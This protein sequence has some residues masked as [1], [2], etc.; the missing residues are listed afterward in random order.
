ME[1]SNISRAFHHLKTVLK[2]KYW[3]FRYAWMAGIPFRGIIHD[4][5]KFSPTEFCKSVKWYN[6]KQ[7]PV[8]CE[9]EVMGFSEIWL[10]HRGH[11]SHHFEYWVYWVDK[12]KDKDLGDGGVIVP[13]MPFKD[14]LEMVCDWLGAGRAYLGTDF[15][16]TKQI[17]YFDRATNSPFIH[18]QTKLFVWLMYQGLANASDKKAM[19]KVFKQ[20]KDIYGRAFDTVI[21]EKDVMCPVKYRG[22]VYVKK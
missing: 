1:F 16:M 11:N 20:A 2:H 3:V 8:A 9:R 14:A 7:S 13:I 10:H 15:S 17:E 19:K 4:F 21:F 5:S 22:F 12:D 6:G 18:P